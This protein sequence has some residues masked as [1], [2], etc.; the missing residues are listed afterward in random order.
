MS[1]RW[2]CPE[3]GTLHLLSNKETAED[4]I[5]H[6]NDCCLVGLIQYGIKWLKRMNAEGERDEI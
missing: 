5:K 4:R 1:D 2:K 6:T 3:C